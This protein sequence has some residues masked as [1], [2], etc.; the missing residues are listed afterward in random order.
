MQDGY[1]KRVE[2]ILCSAEV[3]ASNARNQQE[4]PQKIITGLIH[5]IGR[6]RTELQNARDTLR[7]IIDS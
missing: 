1:L 7:D 3:A 2:A 4:D 6:A 5:D